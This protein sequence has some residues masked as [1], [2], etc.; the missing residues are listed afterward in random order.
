MMRARNQPQERRD[1]TR[2]PVLWSGRFGV[3]GQPEWEWS[4]C[5]VDDVSHGGAR[6]TI[7]SARGIRVGDLIAIAVERL[8]D[9]SVGIRV[10]GKI[11]HLVA[12][13]EVVDVG[14]EL[15]FT[16]P[17]ERRIAETLFAT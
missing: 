16:T 3:N 2:K 4:A 13:G 7:D 1:S 6:I 11:R 14:V 10:H 8:G 5:G 15:E 9:T 12:R 17:Q